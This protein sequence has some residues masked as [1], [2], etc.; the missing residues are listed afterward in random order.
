MIGVYVIRDSEG[1]AIY[2][3]SSSDIDK[4][5][6]FHSSHAPWWSNEHRVERIE[7]SSRAL[8]YSLERERIKALAPERNIVAQGEAKRKSRESGPVVRPRTEVLA[9]MVDAFGSVAALA[10]ACGVNHMTLSDVW[11]GLHYP[12]TKLIARLIIVTGIPMEELFYVDPGNGLIEVSVRPGRRRSII[13]EV[14][15]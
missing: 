14:A 12:S 13:R 5:L 8:A 7:T 15:A 9:E 2:V 3:G 11:R 6:A 4:R 1:R 10:A